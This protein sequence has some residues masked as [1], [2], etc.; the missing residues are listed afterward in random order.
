MV[1]NL[2]AMRETQVRS[3]GWEDPLEK[4]K[5]THSRSMVLVLAAG[6]DQSQGMGV[7]DGDWSSDVCSSDLLE[8]VAISFSRGSPQPRDRTQVSCF[9][10]RRFNLC[11]TREVNNIRHQFQA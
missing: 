10:G 4:G 2:S 9:A 5:A 6:A 11:A 1:K 7:G 3:L 8:W